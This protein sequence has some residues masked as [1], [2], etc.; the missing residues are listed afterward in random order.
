[1]TSERVG[2]AYYSET[3]VLNYD[4]KNF[5]LT[6]PFIPDRV[7]VQAA[8]VRGTD[9]N[10]IA[11]INGGVNYYGSNIFLIQLSCLPARRYIS[12]NLTNTFNPVF[13]FDNTNKYYFQGNYSADIFNSV[14]FNILTGGQFILHFT[15]IKN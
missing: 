5:S 9:T 12:A 11:P 1:M 2:G 15:F 4:N 8:T 3:V 6:C 13:Y 10:P 7:Q 14:N